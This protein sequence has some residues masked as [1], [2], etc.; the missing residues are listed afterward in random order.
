MTGILILAAGASTR[1]GKPKQQLGYQNATLLQHTVQT[2]L[3]IKNAVVLV[4]LGANYELIEPDMAA[5][6]VKIVNNENWEQGMAS[7]IKAGIM[8]LK[9]SFPGVQ[10]V[11]LMLCDQPFVHA[12]LL[13]QLINA[14][15]DSNKAIAACTYQNTYGAPVLFGKLYFDEL[16]N[17]QG[18]QGA[19]PLLL[20]HND[21]IKSIFFAQGKIDIDTPH[22]YKNLLQAGR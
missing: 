15:Q 6:P 19:K 5:L 20:K 14:C 4:V 13:E 9:E 11:L 16:L 3:A 8:A 18:E 21:R 12:A 17:L 10:G 7:S 2:A 1:M 22:D